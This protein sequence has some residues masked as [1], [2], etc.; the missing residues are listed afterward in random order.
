[1]KRRDFIKK[2]SLAAATLPAITMSACNS[3]P[4]SEFPAKKTPLPRRRGFNLL[5]MFL[6]IGNTFKGSGNYDLGPFHEEDFEIIKS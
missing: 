3:A 4:K 2:T 5:N 1:M 6:P